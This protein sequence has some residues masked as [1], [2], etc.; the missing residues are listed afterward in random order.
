MKLSPAAVL[1]LLYG[2]NAAA[3]SRAVEAATFDGGFNFQEVKSGGDPNNTAGATGVFTF[4]LASSLGASISGTA[5]HADIQA[6]RSATGSTAVATSIVSRS[7]GFSS[8]DLTAGLFLRNP[9]IGRIGVSYG[10]G[11][12]R[13]DCG[14]NAMFVVSDGH[15][16]RTYNYAANAE[17]YFSRLTIGAGRTTTHLDGGNDITAD[18]LTA[19]WYPLTELRISPSIGRIDSNNSYGLQLE[20]QP[21]FLGDAVGVVLGYSVQRQSPNIK[22]FSIGFVYH[23]GKPLELQ[24]RDREYR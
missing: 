20:G 12:I 22:S 18:S 9:S 21:E 17:Y 7:C 1:L 8:G 2:A 14:D 3:D 10:A 11:Q 24:T 5:S 23:F 6:D 13:A 16:L 19:S 15:T 4:G